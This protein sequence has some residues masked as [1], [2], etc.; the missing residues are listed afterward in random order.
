VQP[1]IYPAVPAKSARL[2]FFI[3]AQHSK[4]DIDTAIDVLVDEIGKLPQRM[5]SMRLAP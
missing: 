5:R 1:V 2:R 3:T 4:D